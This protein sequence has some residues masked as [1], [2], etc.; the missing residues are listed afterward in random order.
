MTLNIGDQAPL[1]E[2]LDDKGEKRTLADY[3]GQA[4]VVY[5]YPKDDTPGCTSEACAFRDNLSVLNDL[6]AAVLGVSKDSVASHAKFRD[7]Y[8]LTFPLLS[9]EDGAVCEAYGVWQEKSMYGK[10]YM[11]IQRATFL[12]DKDGKIAHIWPKVSVTDH[13]K[14]VKKKI[15]ALT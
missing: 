7:K 1:I 15:E 4:V 5:F 13:V 2:L 6:N 11:G 8:E 10:K 3:K 9:D 14:D 12:V